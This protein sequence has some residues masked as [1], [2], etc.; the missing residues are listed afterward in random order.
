MIVIAALF[1]TSCS[2]RVKDSE[3]L[4]EVPKGAEAVSVHGK[5]FFAGEPTLPASE[6]LKYAKEEWEKDKSNADNFIWYGRRMAYTGAYRETIR[7]FTKGIE[8]FPDDPRMYRHRGH[9]YITIREFQKAVDDFLIAAEMVAGK[10]DEIEPDG[11]P[12][13]LNIPVS[14]LHS[15]IWY[16]L[17]LAYYLLGERELALEAWDSDMALNVNDDMTVATM[18][19]IYMTLRELGQTDEARERLEPITVDMNVKIGRAHV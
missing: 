2:G 3:I 12:N 10:E 8:L 18:H 9:R 14:T 15:N 19:W 7:I 11:M 6:R 1:I 5:P 16:H 17:G 13:A 4:P